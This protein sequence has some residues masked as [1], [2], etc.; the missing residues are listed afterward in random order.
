MS[1]L[2]PPTEDEKVFRQSR[3]AQ[4]T[5]NNG[6]MFPVKCREFGAGEI[7]EVFQKISREEERAFSHIPFKEFYSGVLH[8]REHA[9]VIG[10]DPN[11]VA[12]IAM[13]HLREDSHYYTHLGEMERRVREDA[14]S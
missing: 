1:K 11:K 14:R 5:E 4:W 6:P 8:E 3:A 9:D 7:Y 13:A 2:R 12:M 10:C